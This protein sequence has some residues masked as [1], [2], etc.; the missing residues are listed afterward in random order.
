MSSFFALCDDEKSVTKFTKNLEENI[1]L[2]IELLKQDYLDIMAMPIDRFYQLLRL[3]NKF[4][5]DVSVAQKEEM[6]KIR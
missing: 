5:K 3:K 4:D 2:M 1:F 6:G